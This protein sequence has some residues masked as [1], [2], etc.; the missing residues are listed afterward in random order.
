VVLSPDRTALIHSTG[1]EHEHI[2]TGRHRPGS[3]RGIGAEI[4]PTRRDGFRVV[5]NYAG[6]AG[7][8]AKWSTRSSPTAVRRSPCGERRRS[9]RR[10]LAVRRGH[11]DA[12][13]GIDVV[14]NSAG[15]MKLAAI[16]EF[17]DAVFDNTFAISVRARSTYAA[18]QRSACATAAG[19]S[20]CRPA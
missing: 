19:S 12:F 18:R 7:P 10:H 14:V 20:T 13:G 9:G 15:V 3:S 8:P 11:G 2:G 16:A 6:S 1:A 4:A 5:V 17:D